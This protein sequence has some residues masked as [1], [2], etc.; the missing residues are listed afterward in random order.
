MKRLCICIIG[1]GVAAGLSLQ[2]APQ[3]SSNPLSTEAQQAWTRTIGNAVAAAEQMPEEGY[4]YKP[5]PES[6]SFRDIVAHTADSAMGTCSGLSGERKTAGAA[7]MQGKS[8]LVAAMKAAQAE[9][10]KAYTLTDAKAM[11]VITGGRGGPRSRLSTL[12]GN[13][14]HIEHEYAQMAVLLRS[15]GVVPPSSAGRGGAAGRGAK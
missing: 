6:M 9:C 15:K 3:A 2:A 12:W 4:A 7:Q 11:E 13:T 14:V 1:G 5:S 8:E 10:E